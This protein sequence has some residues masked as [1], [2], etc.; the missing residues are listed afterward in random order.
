MD[1]PMYFVYRNGAYI[2]ALGQSWRDFMKG[3]L[4]ALPGKGEG[5]EGGVFRGGGGGGGERGFRPHVFRQQSSAWGL[6]LMCP[7]PPTQTLLRRWPDPPQPY[8]DDDRPKPR[9]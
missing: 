5:R 8:D 4:P 7:T 2:N 3:K 6:V 1:V 9:T